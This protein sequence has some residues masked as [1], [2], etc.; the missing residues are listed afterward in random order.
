VQLR[1]RRAQQITGI[2][3]M[4]RNMSL[5][6]IAVVV[7]AM[8]TGVHHGYLF[9]P[10]EPREAEIARE[11][12]RDGHWVV[13]HLC[14]LPFLEKPPLYY[15]MVAIAYALTGRITPTVARSVSLA[16]GFLMLIPAFAFG[17]RWRGARMAWL[18]VLILLTMPRFWKYSH[19]ILLDIAVGAFC[20][21]A[22]IC[23]AWSAFWA[24]GEKTKALFLWLCALF[25][26]AAFL[27]KGFAALFSIAVVI[28]GF[29]VVEGRWSALRALFSPLPLLSFLIPVSLWILLFYREGGIGYLHEHFVNNLIGR[30]LQKHYELPAIRFYHTDLGHRLP[31]YFYIQRLPEI[32]GP[33]IVI[34]PCAAWRGIGEMRH[35]SGQ[36]NRSYFSFLLI[37][38]FL[39]AF[40]LSFSGIKERTYILPSYAGM[41]ILIG[42]W[43]DGKLREGGEGLWEGIGWLWIVFPCALFS[44]CAAHMDAARFTV[45]AACALSPAVIVAIILFFKKRFTSAPY[46]AI[47]LMLCVLIVNDSP[48]VLYSRCK[49]KCYLDLTHETWSLVRDH[50][51]YLYK[52]SDNI[53]GSVSFYADRTI[54]EFDRPED[55][56]KVLSGPRRAYVIMEEGWFEEFINDPSFF[57][58]LHVVPAASFDEDP[59]N[60]LLSNRKL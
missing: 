20:T 48:N 49:R 12:L 27:T 13:P 40:L 18:T 54:Q 34:L 23:F 44:L 3:T 50:P 6:L 41:A 43:L 55:L 24:S 4:N 60:M 11:T 15:D 17:H 14:G 2:T 39:P 38:A 10:D 52:P 30:F 22:L 32:L 36:Q 57:D 26:A 28:A 21:W 1:E 47:T 19:V 9:G 53:R 31:W 56:K 59:D 37:W 29:C 51:L 46:V 58:L 35:P 7:A 33:W 8:I 16:F 25:S 5:F 42:Y 45:I